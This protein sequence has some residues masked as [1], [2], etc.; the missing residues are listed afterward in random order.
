[1]NLLHYAKKLYRKINFYDKKVESK[2][3]NSR[4]P[5]PFS[6]KE[7]LNLTVIWV[8]NNTKKL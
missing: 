6:S 4:N 7:P 2:N 3:Y 1:M 8:E 5:N